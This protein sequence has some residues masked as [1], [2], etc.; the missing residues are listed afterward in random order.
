MDTSLF[1]RA[2]ASRRLGVA[3]VIVISCFQTHRSQGQL[4][5]CDQVNV[6]KLAAPVV[7]GYFPLLSGDPAIL[8]DGNLYRLFYTSP[9]LKR[10]QGAIGEAVSS[11]LM[12]WT[13]V[14]AGS[15]AVGKELVLLGQ[16]GQWNEQLETAFA[17][18]HANTYYLYYCGYPRVGWPINPGQIGVATSTD[19]INFQH[20]LGKPVLSATPNNYDA[21]GLYSPV[22]IRYENKFLMIYA[23]HCYASNRVTPG[24]YLL[25]AASGNG[26]SWTKNPSPVLSPDPTVDWLQNG[27]AEPALCPGPDGNFYLFFTA[28]LGDDQKRCIAVGRS[29]SPL[30]PYTIAS[31]PVL[32]GTPGWFDEQGVLAPHVIIEQDKLRMWY[33][34]SRLN[35]SPEKHSIGYAE[36][37]WPLAAFDEVFP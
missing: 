31:R 14:D 28:N 13:P 5:N 17:I 21:N 34:T 33:L 32:S 12:N 10:L 37:P 9:N 19:G 29:R 3:I 22:V 36:M 16:V 23:G 25:S 24:I 35:E 6:K 8:R 4:I 26:L 20:R 1:R 15:D 7:P 18:K 30:G 27:V 11:D 2:L